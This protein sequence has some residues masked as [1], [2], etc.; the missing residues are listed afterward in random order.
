[1][2][3]P[4]GKMSIEKFGQKH[5]NVPGCSASSGWGVRWTF[6]RRSPWFQTR[7]LV[8]SV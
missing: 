4:P 6:Q 7:Y 2:H 1:M 5:M 8:A 3:Q